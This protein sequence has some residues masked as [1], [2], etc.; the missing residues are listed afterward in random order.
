LNNNRRQPVE[1]RQRAQ[2]ENLKSNPQNA[3][4]HWQRR[5]EH[6]TSLARTASVSGNAVDAEY[7]FQHADHYF[8]MIQGTAA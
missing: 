6:F 2:R 4:I 7:Y 8:R 3:R 5:H 1:R